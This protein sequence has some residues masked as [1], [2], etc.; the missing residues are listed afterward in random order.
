MQKITHSTPSRVGF[1]VSTLMFFCREKKRC[2]VALLVNIVLIECGRK[3][4]QPQ[5]TSKGKAMNNYAMGWQNMF[6]LKSLKQT[7][8]D[9]SQFESLNKNIRKQEHKRQHQK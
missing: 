6:H 7:D 2:S 1:F 5:I 8:F 4:E 9:K 3:R